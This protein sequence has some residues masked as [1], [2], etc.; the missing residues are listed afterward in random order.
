MIRRQDI[1]TC[2][3]TSNTSSLITVNK[4]G[5]DRVGKLVAEGRFEEAKQEAKI[6]VDK[7]M[8][9]KVINSNNPVF[10]MNENS[11]DA[12]GILKSETDKEDEFYIYRINN[13]RLNGGSDY[14][15]KSSHQMALLALKMHVNNEQDTGLQ[16]ENAFFNATHMR[17]F[18]FKSFG[19]WL[20]HF[21]H[22][23]NG[24]FGIYGD[25]E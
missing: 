22:E 2:M 4:L 13:G 24:L 6:W 1:S 19:L 3:K 8:A 17:V 16:E 25:E 10:S 23:R 14:V 12:V 21:Q 9:K 5:R 20:V 18:G 11:F 15:F 7:K